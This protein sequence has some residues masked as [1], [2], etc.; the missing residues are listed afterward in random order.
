MKRLGAAR[1]A[2]VVCAE[3]LCERCGVH[4]AARCGDVDLRLPRAAAKGRARAL[5]LPT[6]A[7]E[8]GFCGALLPELWLALAVQ[9]V[10]RCCRASP[11]STPDA[12]AA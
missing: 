11:R 9:L 4:G 1:C 6:G 3:V 5:A 2:G 12:C 10:L 7:G 8:R